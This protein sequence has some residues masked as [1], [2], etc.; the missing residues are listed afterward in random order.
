MLTHAELVA[1]YRSLRNRRVLSVYIDG[2]TT[3]PA[4]QRSWRLQLEHGL[5]D[6]RRWLDGSSRAEHVEL[7]QCI[8]LLETRITDFGAGVGSP[9]WA[10]FITSD[11]VH[12]ARR[13]PASVP[14]LAVWSNGPCVSP[15]VRSLK[16]CR[17][18]IVVIADAK[19][20]TLYRY[21]FGTLERV[22]RVRA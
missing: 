4:I 2:S 15:Y 18:V 1:L 11:R 9:G 19:H 17:P 20:T 10:A 13:L 8:S 14:T 3:D 22:E 5:D 7:E 6:L 21:R 16:E 12:Y